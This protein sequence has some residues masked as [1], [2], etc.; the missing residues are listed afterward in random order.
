MRPGPPR[1]RRDEDAQGHAGDGEGGEGPAGRAQGAELRPLGAHDV[2]QAIAAGRRA[3]GKG[4]AGHWLLLV[5]VAAASYSRLS[6]V[7]AMK[8]SSSE[9]CSGVSSW[10]AIPA[11]R[12]RSASVSVPAPGTE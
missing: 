4:G 6:R 7:S 10:R 1:Q 8:T 9:A 11:A 12:A 5:V 3:G 2:T